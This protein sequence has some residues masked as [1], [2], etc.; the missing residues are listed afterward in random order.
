MTTTINI[1]HAGIE[2]LDI[3]SAKLVI[4]KILTQITL[5]PTNIEQQLEFKI[6]FDRSSGDPREISEIPEVRLW[7]VRLDAAYP[8]LPYIL[9]W[10]SGELGRYTAM[11][12]PHEFDQTKGIEY[13]YEAMQIFVMSKIFVISSWLQ[14][15]QVL[16]IDKL[17]QMT[18]VLGYE[19]DREFFKLTGLTD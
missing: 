4:D 6:F 13:N 19:I 15:H 7:F 17:Q 18:Q 9:N 12:V 16:S 2:N 1:N 11:L 3:T 8:W 5:S 10:R 14:Q